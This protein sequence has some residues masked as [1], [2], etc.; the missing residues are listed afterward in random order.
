MLVFRSVGKFQEKRANYWQSSTR[1]LLRSGIKIGH[2]FVSLFDVASTDGFLLRAMD[3]YLLVGRDV[4]GM[5]TIDRLEGAKFEPLRQ[6]LRPRTADKATH[7]R[8]A[9]AKTT[10][11]EVKEH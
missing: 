10:Q 2:Q 1:Q 8:S 4:A 5:I 11:P 6:Q 3:P 7:I 9:H